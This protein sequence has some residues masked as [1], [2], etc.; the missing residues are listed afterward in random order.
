MRILFTFVGAGSGHV[1]PLIPIARAAEA[2][3]HAVAFTGSPAMVPA[4]KGEG[5]TVFPTGPA[6]DA[7]AAR[8]IPLRDLSAEREDNVLREYFA[9]R[10]RRCLRDLPINVAVT[11]GREIDPE[12]LGPQPAN[13][14]AAPH[15]CVSSR[16]VTPDCDARMRDE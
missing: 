12:E 15:S 5:L 4:V 2:A 14:H 11:V 6:E 1:D 7:L 9:A 3:G 10:R 13:V 8:R 16:D